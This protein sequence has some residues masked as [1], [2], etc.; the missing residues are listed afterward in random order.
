MAHKL[1]RVSIVGLGKLGAPLAACFASKGFPTIGLDVDP[2]KVQAVNQGIAPV[3]EPGLQ[4]LLRA[5]Q[6]R[7]S[8]TED[9]EK[10]VMHSDVTFIIVPTPSNDYGSFSLRYVLE[11]AERIGDALRKKP[12]YHLVVLTSTVMPGATE[13]EVKPLLEVRSSKRCGQDFG[14]CYSPQFIALGSA[15][16]DFLNPDF[17]LIG[18]S[19]RRSGEMLACLFRS[20]CETEP[21]V[22]QMNFVN[23]ELTKLAV[24]TYV[25]TKITFANMLA[26]I[27]ERLPDANVDVVASALGL[28]SRIGRKC[29][30]GAIGY[31]GPCF[32]RDNIA[33]AALARSVAAPATLAEATD[34]FNRQQ[35]QWLATLVKSH[36]PQHG[37]VGILGLAY[38]PNSDVAEHSQGLL[39]AQT[40][41]S[42][43]VAVIAYDPTAMEEARRRL[44]N[45]VTFVTSAPD[46]I[47]EADV[48]V[49][50]TPWDEFKQLTPAAIA[51][52]S[53]PRV[54][55]DC[56]R[57]LDSFNG[58]DGVAYVPLGLGSLRPSVSS[59]VG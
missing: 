14:L 6:G 24:N 9:Y 54:V 59:L 49:V 57:L 36:L 23:A 33:L 1:E 7:L 10:A 13:G 29:L 3:F 52:H 48:I 8:G 22:A 32:P 44:D 34:A 4:D 38:K 43:G 20:V 39:L 30:K 17:V 12:A 42:D 18:E 21:P 11:V 28:D 51:R 55:I 37:R 45:R 2:R 47:Q 25:T 19:E 27:C 26:R 35:V 58:Y 31:G 50:T 41:A 5:S 46:C 16:R 56:W 53:P 40:L 15:I